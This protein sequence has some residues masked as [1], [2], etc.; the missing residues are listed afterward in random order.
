MSK[1]FDSFSSLIQYMR[2][3]AAIS[4]LCLVVAWSFPVQAASRI[5]PQLEQQVLQI[6]REHP[7]AIIESVQVYQQQQQQKLKQAQQ[8]FLQDLK[9]NPQTVIGESPTTGSTKS[10]TVLIEFSD[11]QCP[12]C[13]EAHKTLKQ[14]LA[15]YPDK[16]KLVYKNLPL[17]SIHAEALPSAKAAWAAYQQGKFWEYHDALFTNQKQLGEAL[18]LDIAKKLNL[19][20]SKFK[21]DLTLATPAITKDIQLAEKLGVSGTPFFVINSPTFSGVPQLADIENIL[22]GAK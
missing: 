15:K 2:T 13:A 16:V 12:Y 11:F 22:I 7:Q 5:D 18:Y 8:A 21:R 20:L 6:I 14:L 1:F 9:T 10:K 17:I 3:W 4:L 19:D